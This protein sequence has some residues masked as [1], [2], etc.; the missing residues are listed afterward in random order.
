M[1]PLYRSKSS[2]QYKKKVLTKSP[3]RKKFTVAKT[4]KMLYN[5]FH[6]D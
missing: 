3:V 2:C 1:G 5:P 6:D 4:G